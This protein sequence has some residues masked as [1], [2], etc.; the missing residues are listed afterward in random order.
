MGPDAIV[1]YV[2]KDVLFKASP[3]LK[4][5]FSGN[6][7]EATDMQ[8]PLPE[9]DVD[10]VDRMIQFLYS[11]RLDV[12]TPENPDA[13]NECYWQLAKLNVI[14]DKYDILD[15][16]NGIIDQLFK[17]CR[18]DING[19]RAPVVTFVYDHTTQNSLF[20]K[21][22]VAG[23]VETVS[24]KWYERETCRAILVANPEFAADLAI[25]AALRRFKYK[26]TLSGLSS[27]FHET[28][29]VH[30]RPTPS[31]QQRDAK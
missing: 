1:Y 11:R 29:T 6:F 12:T 25:A 27:V 4:A 7:K 16:K 14:A 3:V 13:L 24:H 23:Y 22:I 21:V 9:D 15:L 2:H 26:Y 10:S 31:T 18:S 5:A 8:M 17:L 19:P 30:N 28:P 20:R